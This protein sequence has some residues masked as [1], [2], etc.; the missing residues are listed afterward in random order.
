ML[1]RAPAAAASRRCFAMP[2]VCTWQEESLLWLVCLLHRALLPRKLT[3][4]FGWSS[5][6]RMGQCR[7]SVPQVLL[8]CRFVP[9][10][11]GLGT[12]SA[13]CAAQVRDSCQR[14]MHLPMT[15]NPSSAASLSWPTDSQS[16][17]GW[18]AHFPHVCFAAWLVPSY[19]AV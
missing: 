4:A 19:P 15:Q 1:L 6:G 10:T 9:Q 14:G 2:S 17:T 5:C 11:G 7:E 12:I 3:Q 16:Q 18:H 13:G 8:P